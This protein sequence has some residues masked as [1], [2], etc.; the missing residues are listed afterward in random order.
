MPIDKNK[1]KGMLFGA[2]YGD[3]YSLGGHW[4]YDTNELLN[5]NLN[6]DECNNPLSSYHPTKVKGDFT[7]YGDQM[8]WLLESLATEQKF[9]LIDFGNTW[10]NNMKEYKGYID[11]ASNH[12]LEKLANE[13]NYFAC[14]SLS[15][16]LSAVSRI[17]PL[18]VNYHNEPDEM[19]E[20]IKL[21][22]ILTHMNKDLIQSGNFFGELA[23]ALLRGGDLEKSIEASYKHFGE[24]I[25]SW[26]EQAKEVLHLPA[27]EA[28]AKLGQ[29]CSANGAFASTIYILL[30][31]H[32]NFNDAL[33]ENML[34]GGESA[35]RGMLIGGLLGIIHNEDVLNTP[36]K[37][38]INKNYE[39]EELLKK[40][41]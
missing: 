10:N 5:A 34:A 41:I 37:K 39:I 14:G 9:S 20:A 27:K 26:V 32:N 8:L 15:S 33:R 38:Q 12:T 4:V 2:F 6:L 17:F 22:T 23:L 21:H 36:S 30:K 18:I 28:I 3:A 1:L 16:D 25:I 13:K 11:G 40:I 35:A 31:Y 29:A 24:N 7:H 19:Q